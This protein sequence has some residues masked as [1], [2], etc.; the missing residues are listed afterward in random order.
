MKKTRR[1]FFAAL[2]GAVAAPVL[3]AKT[4]LAKSSDPGYR[5]I[6]EHS[7][8]FDTAE[9][10]SYSVESVWVNNA[11]P[12][13]HELTLPDLEKNYAELSALGK[14]LADEERIYYTESWNRIQGK[15]KYSTTAPW[16]DDFSVMKLWPEPPVYPLTFQFSRLQDPDSWELLYINTSINTNQNVSRNV[17][18]LNQE[19]GNS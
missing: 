14:S 8:T 12:E 1:G 4:A 16:Y 13:N 15:W 2:V 10:E 9:G 18:T 7:V 19:R 3:L 6:D 5:V 11:F 17:G